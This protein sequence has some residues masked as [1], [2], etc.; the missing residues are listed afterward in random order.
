[1]PAPTTHITCSSL[2]FAWPDGR[3]VFE[4]FQLA[5]GPGRTG[6]IGLNGCGKSTL[7]RLIMR[8]THAYGRPH[9]HGRRHRLPP[10][11]PR[12]GHRPAGRRG[13]G[14]RRETDRAERHRVGR[15]PRGALR[16]GRRRLGRGGTRPRHARP[17]GPRRYRARPDHRRDVGR[18]VR[19]AAAGRAAAGT[20]VGPAAGRADE[21]SRPA[22][23]RTA[24]R[25]GRRLDRCP[26]R[27]QSRP[28]A[29]G[30][31][32][33]DRR[34]EGGHGH[35]VRRQSVGVRGGARRGAGG[36]GA[37][38]AGRGGRCAAAEA[39]TVLRTHQVGPT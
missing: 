8:R 19:A 9:H 39:R 16:R 7:L 25:R 33:P 4:D 23:P 5:V 28:G 1:M 10:A 36:R 30:A 3:D 24:V 37:D 13:A 17:A 38:G 22:R 32:G 18:R 29:A 11:E 26:G 6:L 12:P 27:R 34:S 15:C 2:S 35:L 14:H 21:Q 20:S 31:R